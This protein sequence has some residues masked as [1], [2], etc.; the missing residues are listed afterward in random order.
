MSL[1]ANLNDETFAK[2]APVA[3]SL[4]SVDVSASSVSEATLAAE[5]PKMISLRRL[6]LSQ[7]QVTD[8]LLD[9]IAKIDG[10]E[11]LNV[12]G[13]KVTDAG[14]IKLKTLTGLKQFFGWQSGVTE[15]GAKALKK[16]LPGLYVNLGGFELK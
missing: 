3:S 9:V 2:L 5:L 14:I 13:T 10:L 15:E 6:N 8:K 11:Y 12:Y 1:R 7:T 4:V 16:E